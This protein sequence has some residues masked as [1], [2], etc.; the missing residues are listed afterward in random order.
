MVPM[1]TRTIP[2]A[3]SLNPSPS[4]PLRSSRRSASS[5]S[6][7]RFGGR[8]AIGTV[9]LGLSAVAFLLASAQLAQAQD[10]KM[11]VVLEIQGA[12]P[13]LQAG[14]EKALKGKYVVVPVAKW[15]SAATRLN[16]TGQGTDEI[17]LVAGDLKVDAVVTGK[18]KQDKDS[19]SYK[20]N[21]AA[22]HG[23]TGKPLGKLTYE[24]KSP[25]VD[26]ATIAQAELD[27]DKAVEQALAGPPPEAP[28]VAAAAPA[29]TPT[30]S[31]RNE[32][33]NPIEKLKKLEA[34]DKH[35]REHVVRPVYYPYFDVGAAFIINGR[36]F[37]YSE[38]TGTSPNKC[39]D[40]DR[41]TLD[42]NDPTNK[43]FVYK[44]TPALKSC[45]RYAPSVTGGVRV[46]LTGFPLAGVRYNGLRGLGIGITFDY[47]FWP[48]SMTAGANPRSLDTREFRLEGGLR[49]HWNVANKR[50][51][52]SILASVQYGLH[53]FAVAKEQKTYSYVDDIGSTQTA[54]GIDDHG[55][56]DILYQYVT[57]GLGG[58]IPYY[59]TEKLYFGL[60]VNF[61]FH[62]MLS[63]GELGTGFAD[64]STVTS[65]YGSGGYGQASGYGFRAGFTPLELIPWKGIT[66]RLSGF[67][68]MFTTAFALGSNNNNNVSL[69]PVDRT[70]DNAARHI[71]QGAVDQYFGGVVQIGYQY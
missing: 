21:I 70:L 24:L 69:P 30:P 40:F 48:P 29:E 34:Q 7:L 2:R 64:S 47:M 67:Y 58:R 66:I 61:N 20:L 39:Y 35:D 41:R 44:Y 13:K 57:I 49:Y 46:D 16:A 9:L 54:A 19:G 26:S 45:P 51:L 32:D 33:E 6:G 25:K 3:T 68:E 4:R 56:P 42:P 17:A 50:S 1:S 18:V 71:A 31:L 22:R 28:V 59:A 23:A 52:P 43:N 60:L 36:S 8:G 14:L 27:I 11:V 55:L 12:P 15:N 38:E 65:L 10:K 53:S 62:A 37:S 63:F 5:G